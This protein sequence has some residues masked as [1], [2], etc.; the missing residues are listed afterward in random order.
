MKVFVVDDDPIYKRIVQRMF[1][2]IDDALSIRFFGD[3][4]KAMDVLEGWEGVA[5]PDIIML[6]IEMPELDGWG[7]MDAFRQLPAAAREH[8]K[9]YIITSSIANEDIQKAGRYP[10]IIGYI[11]KPITHQILKR[12]VGQQ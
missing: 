10:E 3:G 6:D 11:P 8:T 1:N 9:V 5:F 12:I 4:R 2:E 7:F